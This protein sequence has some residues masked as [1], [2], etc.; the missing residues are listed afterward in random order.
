MAL[1]GKTPA[2]VAGIDYDV[3]NWM[4]VSRIPVSKKAEILSHTLPKPILAKTS[5]KG[6]KLYKRKRKKKA[7]AEIKTQPSLRVVRLK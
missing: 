7:R 2:E 5:L 1:D 6:K 3:K 4:D